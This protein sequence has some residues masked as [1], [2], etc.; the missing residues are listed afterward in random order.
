MVI[1]PGVTDQLCRVCRRI[2]DAATTPEP[3]D[4][5]PRDTV[6]LALRTRE[7]PPP[8]GDYRARGVLELARWL[9]AESDSATPEPIVGRNPRDSGHMRSF[10]SIDQLQ[11][12]THG[13]AMIAG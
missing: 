9:L 3:V 10:G 12:F 8:A 4:P 1:G 5:T 7:V 13:H 2:P 11:F 6:G